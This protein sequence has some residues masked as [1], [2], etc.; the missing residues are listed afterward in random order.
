MTLKLEITAK[1]MDV[2]LPRELTLRKQNPSCNLK[3]CLCSIYNKNQL[4]CF[5]IKKEVDEDGYLSIG[6]IKP[7]RYNQAQKIIIEG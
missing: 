4:V 7:C 6:E 3:G 1:P 5:K 2:P